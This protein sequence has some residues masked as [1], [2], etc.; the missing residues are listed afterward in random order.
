MGEIPGKSSHS[1]QTNATPQRTNNTRADQARNNAGSGTGID[2]RRVTDASGQVRH[3]ERSEMR[4]VKRGRPQRPAYSLSKFLR[5]CEIGVLRPLNCRPCNLVT[6]CDDPLVR[7]GI[8]VWNNPGQLAHMEAEIAMLKEELKRQQP[9]T[10]SYI[11]SVLS[12]QREQPAIET[13]QNESRYRNGPITLEY[14]KVYKYDKLCVLDPCIRLLK[15]ILKDDKLIKMHSQKDIMSTK[16]NDI[17]IRVDK[18][19]KLIGEDAIRRSVLS[20]V[21]LVRVQ[22]DFHDRSNFEKAF[23]P[24]IICLYRDGDIEAARQ[25]FLSCAKKLW[26]DFPTRKMRFDDDRLCPWAAR[27]NVV[28]TEKDMEKVGISGEKKEFILD[29]V[30]Y[31]YLCAAEMEIE[32]MEGSKKYDRYYPVPRASFWRRLQGYLDR[33]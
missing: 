8:S 11:E 14:D 23:I 6:A 12:L 10:S 21:L 13:P 17:K 30:Y 32:R 20:F 22:P 25:E 2:N 4:E 1:L 7:T 27:S 33:A 3:G 5:D 24:A 18:L 26:P 15:L 31:Y 16:R 19:D 29:A 28:W 9:M